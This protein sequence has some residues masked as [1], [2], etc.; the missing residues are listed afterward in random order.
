MFSII[1]VALCAGFL[2]A[3]DASCQLFR[4]TGG[5]YATAKE[6]EIRLSEVRA[7]W[8]EAFA[9]IEGVVQVTMFIPDRTCIV[10]DKPPGEP[11]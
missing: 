6:C 7:T 4:D 3:P 8:P 1:D 2:A 11:V 9:R 5:P 10:K